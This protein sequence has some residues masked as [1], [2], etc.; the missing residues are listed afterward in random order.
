VAI[1]TPILGRSLASI[2]AC[3]SDVV[4][5][6]RPMEAAALRPMEVAAAPSMGVAA[7]PSMEVA[8]ALGVLPS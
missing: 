3:V 5:Y 1:C 8:R 6:L 2:E 4:A 7:A